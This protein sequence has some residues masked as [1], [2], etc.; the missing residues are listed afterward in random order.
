MQ[1]DSRPHPN[2]PEELT[3]VNRDVSMHSVWTWRIVVHGNPPERLE[4][5]QKSWFSRGAVGL[6][7]IM[8][9]IFLSIALAVRHFSESLPADFVRVFFNFGIIAAPVSLILYP[10]LA[11]G[12]IEFDR[13]RWGGKRRLVFDARERRLEFP[14]EGVS[15]EIDE[16]ARLI[17][18][19]TNGTLCS[20]WDGDGNLCNQIYFLIR[21][22][23]GEWKRHPIGEVRNKRRAE[24]VLARLQAVM[25]CEIYRRRM[26]CLESLKLQFPDR[27]RW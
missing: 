1:D 24:E 17:V 19:H 10:L 16:C 6:G 13:R 20:R 9:A 5:T 11:A 4:I 15:Y 21:R 23:D 27:K 8:G 2:P 26:G 12:F 14:C 3:S 22:T 18:A 25:D 7:V